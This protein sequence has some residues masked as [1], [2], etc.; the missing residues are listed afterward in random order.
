MKKENPSPNTQQNILKKRL[1]VLIIALVLCVVAA[2]AIGRIPK[3]TEDSPPAVTDPDNVQIQTEPPAKKAGWLY[4]HGGASF[5]I[6]V[7]EKERLTSFDG[8]I[9]PTVLSRAEYEEGK[10]LEFDLNL[11]INEVVLADPVGYVIAAKAANEADTADLLMLDLRVNTSSSQPTSSDLLSRGLLRDASRLEA[12]RLD[13]AG[14]YTDVNA[15]LSVCGG[16]YFVASD[17]TAG[18]RDSLTGVAYN[19]GVLSGREDAIHSLV[20]EGRWTLDEMKALIKEAEANPLYTDSHEAVAWMMGM[21]ASDALPTDS[22]FKVAI[23][24]ENAVG[25]FRRM[26]DAL[27]ADVDENA[28]VGTP[29]A[30]F[31]QVSVSEFAMMD[32]NLHGLLPLP[33]SDVSGEYR[34][35]A[36]CEQA[37]VSAITSFCADPERSARVLSELAVRSAALAEDYISD[38]CRLDTKSAESLRLMMKNRAVSVIS[39]LGYPGVL[40]DACE[41]LLLEKSTDHEA[42]LKQRSYFLEYAFETI[43]SEIMKNTAANAN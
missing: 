22:G 13:E 33:K 38:A 6:L 23:A 16:V 30:V 24:D 21:G 39:V 37:T 10:T 9:G 14:F 15:S 19:R 20:N 43:V 25:L 41:T 1:P 11:V 40:E 7:S 31:E 12:L 42:F 29:G 26:R 18:F 3:Q 32:K 27:Y 8:Q 2:F 34:A 17:A 36:D 5:K 28:V 35:F 4:D